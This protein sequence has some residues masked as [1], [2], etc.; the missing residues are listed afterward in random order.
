MPRCSCG[1]LQL[2]VWTCTCSRHEPPVRL[3]RE[4]RGIHAMAFRASSNHPTNQTSFH[5]P[6]APSSTCEPLPA[7]SSAC[8]GSGS[9]PASRSRHSSTGSRD[10]GAADGGHIH[11][12]PMHP[13][14][15]RQGPSPQRESGLLR[16]HLNPKRD[17]IV[18]PAPISC[19]RST[20]LSTT[21][22]TPN[23]PA[24]LQ[25]FFFFLFSILLTRFFFQSSREG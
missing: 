17:W 3:V 18:G 15:A 6:A 9:R 16:S 2:Q 20:R 8:P 24:R 7:F 23:P 11:V 1:K 21:L 25:S 5:V 13:W 14:R 4:A 10:A 19:S 12:H 22:C